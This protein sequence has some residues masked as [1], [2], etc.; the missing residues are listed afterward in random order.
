MTTTT[1]RPVLPM[2]I[3]VAVCFFLVAV[4]VDDGEQPRWFTG[5]VVVIIE[6]SLPV[7]TLHLHL[8]SRPNPIRGHFPVMLFLVEAF[9]FFLCSCFSCMFSPVDVDHQLVEFP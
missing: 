6:D 3:I 8:H 1:I 2:M 4:V 5:R 7:P 9:F